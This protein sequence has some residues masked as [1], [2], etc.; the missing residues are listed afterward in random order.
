[1]QS[2]LPGALS[3]SVALSGTGS[4]YIE[5][6]WELHSDQD[7]IVDADEPHEERKIYRLHLILHSPVLEVRLDPP[8]SCTLHFA[9]GLRLTMFD[10]LGRYECFQMTLDEPRRSF[11]C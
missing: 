8:R 3:N 9:N 5:G 1:M 4:F 11:I 6:A 2:G 10:D 7:R